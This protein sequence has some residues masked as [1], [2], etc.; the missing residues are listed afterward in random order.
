MRAKLP[1]MDAI[2]LDSRRIDELGRL[3]IPPA[4][5]ALLGVGP[6]EH[7]RILIQDGQVVLRGEEDED[8]GEGC[9][10]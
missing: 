9:G 1:S 6:G 4:A 10:A 2:H 5:R 8:T 7:V 3:V